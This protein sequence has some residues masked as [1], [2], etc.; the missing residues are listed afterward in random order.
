[1]CAFYRRA[2]WWHVMEVIFLV[3]LLQTSSKYKSTAIFVLPI[4]CFHFIVLFS[5][6]LYPKYKASF[7]SQNAKQAAIFL[8]IHSAPLLLWLLGLRALLS[9]VG[10]IRSAWERSMRAHNELWPTWQNFPHWLIENWW[11]SIPVHISKWIKAFLECGTY[12][13]GNH[14]FYLFWNFNQWGKQQKAL[15]QKK[16]TTGTFYGIPS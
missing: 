12:K 6:Y 9:I 13:T 1:M 14:N 7:L 15:G 11:T 5:Q 16:K 2:L 10:R 8:R 3:S 4:F